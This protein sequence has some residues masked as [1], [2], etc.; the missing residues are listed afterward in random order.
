MHAESQFGL[1][2]HHLIP[3]QDFLPVNVIDH[4]AGHADHCG[5]KFGLSVK[6]HPESPINMEVVDHSIYIDH[7]SLTLITIVGILCSPLVLY[8][9]NRSF[10][11]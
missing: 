8:L 4:R 10:G 2:I 1:I 9:G 3:I 6:F 5:Q 7:A 11:I